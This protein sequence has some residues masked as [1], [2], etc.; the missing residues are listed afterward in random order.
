MGLVLVRREATSFGGFGINSVGRA[1]DVRARPAP[2]FKLSPINGQPV[3]LAELRGQTIVLNFWASWCP[4]CR[5]EARTLESAW[6]SQQGREVVFVGVNLW[7]ADPEARAFLDHFGVTY[8]NGLDPNGRLA[9]EYG[10][11]GIPETFGINRDGVLVKR[12]IGP[13]DVLQLQSFVQE[14]TG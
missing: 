4:P 14:L 8:P 11:T 5:E 3:S 12:W 1:V 7:D 13:M 10:V 9:I 6:R 2:D